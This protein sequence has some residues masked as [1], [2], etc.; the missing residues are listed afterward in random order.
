MSK[1]RVIVAGSR[2]FRDY[3]L[4]SATLDRICQ[5]KQVII[6][7]GQARGADS[8]GERYARE[9]G[10][11]IDPHPADW[12][13]YGKSAGFRR[14]EEMA[15]CADMLVA[16]WDG[17]SRGTHHMITTASRHMLPIE[18]VKYMPV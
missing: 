11:E 16:F 15:N 8:L 13:Q 18:I 6:V 17:H 2:D 3:Q 10:L 12:N 14:N 5:D 7:S 1:F 9:H 4:L